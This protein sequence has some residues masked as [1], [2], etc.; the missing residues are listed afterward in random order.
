MKDL[1]EIIERLLAELPRRTGLSELAYGLT[2]VPM[3]SA[4]EAGEA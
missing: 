2:E 1:Y 4:A 3:E